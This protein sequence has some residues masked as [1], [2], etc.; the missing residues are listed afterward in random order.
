MVKKIIFP[1]LVLMLSGCAAMNASGPLF[2]KHFFVPEGKAL[3][4]LMKPDSVSKDGVTTCLTLALGDTEYGCVRGEGY[5]VAEVDAG[6]YQAALVNKAGFGYKLLKFDLEVRS[7]EAVYLEYAFGRGLTGE[8]LDTR[9]AN[10][11]LIISG[12]H[13]VAKI[14]EEEALQKLSTLK[15]S[16]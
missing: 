9:F 15:L 13:V 12:N 4:Y 8:S 5:I 16:I 6:K 14:Q 1:L 7:R 11:G 10:I 2:E 3:V